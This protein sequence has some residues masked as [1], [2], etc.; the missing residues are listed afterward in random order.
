MQIFVYWPTLTGRAIYLLKIIVSRT[1]KLNESFFLS[2]FFFFLGG[3]EGA[4]GERE[5]DG[6]DSLYKLLI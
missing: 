2:L 4:G 3:G 5:R 1:T 6:G